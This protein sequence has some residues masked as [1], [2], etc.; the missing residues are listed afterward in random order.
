M[1]M[2]NNQRVSVSK[3]PG[4]THENP[5]FVG[6]PKRQCPHAVTWPAGNSSSWEN[7][8]FFAP[9]MKYH[10]S[11]MSFSTSWFTQK[12]MKKTGSFRLPNPSISPGFELPDCRSICFLNHLARTNPTEPEVSTCV[13]CRLL[14][15]VGEWLQFRWNMLDS[16]GLWK[17]IL[18]SW[19]V[20]KVPCEVVSTCCVCRLGEIYRF[21]TLS[22]ALEDQSCRKCIK[23]QNIKIKSIDFFLGYPKILW[24]EEILHQLVDGLSHCNPIIYS[25]L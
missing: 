12:K 14:V 16:E 10:W 22:E 2:L 11:K 13:Y 15:N 17:I 18:R 24:M 23:E 8:P 1:A 7:P 19:P 6:Y 25:V 9:R 4:V 20:N 3:N 21:P 5:P